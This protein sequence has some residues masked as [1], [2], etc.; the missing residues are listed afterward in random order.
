LMSLH[1]PLRGDKFATFINAYALPI[2]SSEAPK[3]KFYEDLHVLLAT[4]SKMD[5]LIVL[6]E[7][8]ARAGTDHAAWQEEQ[9]STFLVAVTIRASFFCARVLNTIF[10]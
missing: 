4:V 10:C 3:Y 2:K 1:L 6:G 7:F 9:V 5:K 8:N